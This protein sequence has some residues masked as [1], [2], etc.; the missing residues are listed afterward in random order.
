[1]ATAIYWDTSALLKLYAPEPDSEVYRKLLS[2]HAEQVAIS[3]LHHVELYYALSGKE[4]RSEIAQGGANLLFESFQRHRQEGRFLEIPWGDDVGRHAREALV[5]CHAHL[6]P[7]ML[8]SLDGFHLGA[9][10]AAG[11]RAVV[12][13][14]ARFR[15]AAVCLGLDVIGD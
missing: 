11:I 6:P 9:I 7:V 14:D 12:T 1:M 3:F 10:R 8:R 2:N 4:H 5:L 13:T 15:Q